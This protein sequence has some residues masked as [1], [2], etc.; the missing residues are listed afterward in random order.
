MDPRLLE[1]INRRN[2]VVLVGAGA[3]FDAG[4]PSWRRLTADVIEFAVQKAPSIKEEANKLFA[5]RK[6]PEVMQMVGD[7]IGREVLDKYI[8]GKVS[9]PNES[10]LSELLTSF[11][12]AFYMTTNYDDVLKKSLERKGLRPV[13]L[14][15]SQ[16]D[17]NAIAGDTRN[18]I[19][20]LHGDFNDPSSHIILTSGDYRKLRVEPS[21][22][23][24]RLKL[25]SIFSMFDVLI[26]GY[27]FQDP[28]LQIILEE[29]SSVLKPHRPIFAMV[30]DPS[31]FTAKEYKK[32]FNVEVIGYKTIEESHSQLLSTLRGMEPFVIGRPI[33]PNRHT[34]TPES[35]QAADLFLFTSF[36][37]RNEALDFKLSSYKSIVLHAIQSEKERK[38]IVDLA[39][40]IPM[41]PGDGS[42]KVL[43][44]LRLATG[45][46]QSSGLI[47]VDSDGKLELTPKG[48]DDCSGAKRKADLAAAQFLEQV[49]ADVGASKDVAP[50]RRDA[51]GKLVLECVSNVF[52]ARGLEIAGSLFADRAVDLKGAGDVFREIKT[53]HDALADDSERAFFTRYV[54][55]LITNPKETQVPFLS[56]LAQAYFSYHA[57]NL[58]P[59][60]SRIQ[61]ELLSQSVFILDS[62]II[63]PFL[64]RGSFS[65]ESANRLFELAKRTGATLVTTRRILKEVLEHAS[66][67]KELVSREKIQSPQ[68]MRVALGLGGSKQNLFIDGYIRLA[69]E[70]T[71]QFVDYM[72]EIFGKGGYAKLLESPGNFLPNVHVIDPVEDAVVNSADVERD[73]SQIRRYREP[74]GT[75]RHED[76]CVAEAEVF[77]LMGLIAAGGDLPGVLKG[78]KEAFFISQSRVLDRFRDTEEAGKR[79]VWPGESFYRYLGCFS[80]DKRAE[81]SWQEFL[82]SDAFLRGLPVIDEEKYREFFSAPIKQ[83]KMSFES[84]RKYFARIRD[85]RFVSDLSQDF[86]ETPDLERPLFVETVGTY[87]ERALKDA[88]TLNKDERAELEK[89]RQKDRNIRDY[90]KK[91]KK[92]KR[93][94]QKKKRR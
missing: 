41:R 81:V 67:A 63:I 10:R 24:F 93:E 60:C 46:L 84:Q 56:H 13:V 44:L 72:H 92:Q 1:A 65:H 26:V 69:T 3:S 14:Q 51:F 49:L 25:R 64:A 23:Y 55:S 75:F 19:L 62:N 35:K 43:S 94:S 89:Y 9:A 38:S 45:S 53:F 5:A 48:L 77:N 80:T 12:F 18:V 91:Q 50:S 30:S 86:D 61:G 28:H 74:R 17:F 22:E 68:F 88:K 21:F 4:L 20:K 87:L 42:E 16:H 90:A 66:F 33:Y 40:K 82:A 73:S 54:A 7:A 83:A 8:S 11:P 59:G 58:D 79:T 34:I 47:K 32:A 70:G 76:Q 15:N 39:A 52:H 27:S 29:L 57:L 78:K 37:L 36:Q 85:E 71:L 31:S 6:Y 2:C